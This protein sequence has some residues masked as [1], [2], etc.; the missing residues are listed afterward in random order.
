MSKNFSVTI[1]ILTHMLI[2]VGGLALGSEFGDTKAFIILSDLVIFSL[3]GTL[4]FYIYGLREEH[5]N[6]K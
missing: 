5:A 4:I 2:F 3:I 6:A 1:S